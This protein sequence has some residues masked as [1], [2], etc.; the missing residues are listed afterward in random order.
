MGNQ[1]NKLA[2]GA[3][4]SPEEDSFEIDPAQLEWGDQIGSGITAL[5]YYG[6]YKGR[7]VAI[8]EINLD[9]GQAKTVIQHALKSFEREAEV[10]PRI[11]HPNLVGLLGVQTSRMPLLLLSEYCAGGSL[12]QLLHN[13]PDIE[14]SWSQRNKMLLDVALAVDY[15]HNFDP[16]IIHRDIKSLN[17]LLQ[18]FVMDTTDEPM[19]QL[20][21][22]GFARV[23]GSEEWGKMT[24][25]AGTFHWMAPEVVQ[26]NYNEKADIFSYA[27]ISYEVA[28]RRVPFEKL[29][30]TAA[31]MNFYKG[32]RP[33]LDEIS[34][35]SDELRA[36]LEELLTKCWAQ[37]PSQRPSATECV[38]MVKALKDE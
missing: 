3:D 26:G 9:Q 28:C 22:F 1:A 31:I 4:V 18:N 37:D 20:S 13:Q 24:K 35:S 27:M 7:E 2:Q 17:L 6:K 12:F 33:G 38:A 15:L 5:V 32:K 11:N 16:Q 36:Q 23:K 25:Q 21:D 34:E 19:V 30:A 29:A 8:K 10:W 14:L